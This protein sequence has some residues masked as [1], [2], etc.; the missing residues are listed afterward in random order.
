V[1]YDGEKL[2]RG[3][4]ISKKKAEQIACDDAIKHLDGF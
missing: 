3:M 2:G 1:F 4:D